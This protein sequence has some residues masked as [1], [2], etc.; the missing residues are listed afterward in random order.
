MFSKRTRFI[1]LG[2]LLE[3]NPL[4]ALVVMVL[5]IHLATMPSIVA[6]L[7]NSNPVT[8]TCETFW[9]HKPA[10]PFSIQK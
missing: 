6:K 5:W 10:K 8:I 4:H 9:M 7:G 3:I 2:F 1:T